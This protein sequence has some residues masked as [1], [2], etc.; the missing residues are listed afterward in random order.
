MNYPDPDS[1]ELQLRREGNPVCWECGY[2]IVATILSNPYR[3]GWTHLTFYEPH[4][5]IPTY[6]YG[7]TPRALAIDDGEPPFY[8]EVLI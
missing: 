7:H 2:T 5:E 4:P 1:F 3:D 8:Q 6:P